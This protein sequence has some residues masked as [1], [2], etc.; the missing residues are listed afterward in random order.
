MRISMKRIY[1][2]AEKSDGARILV[3]RLWPRGV[4]KEAAQIDEWAK[5]LAPSNGLR[6]WLH[7]DHEGRYE[8]F[9]AKYRDELD[10]K[11]EAAQR[12]LCGR[13]RITL[14]TSA[15]NV[16]HSHVPVLNELLVRLLAN[17]CK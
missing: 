4:S 6:K 11:T 2:E 9:R 10:K 16:K 8:E 17:P 5:D 13:Q 1:D 15:K 3:D 7:E 12:L 14:V